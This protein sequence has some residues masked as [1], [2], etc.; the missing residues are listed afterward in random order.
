[1][2][3]SFKLV[4]FMVNI[5][6]GESETID[7]LYKE[8]K[9]DG[10]ATL[11]PNTEEESI[12]KFHKQISTIGGNDKVQIVKVMLFNDN[13]MMIKSEELIKPTEITE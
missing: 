8:V 4:T 9:I 7:H 1:M 11:V 6:G 13:G 2:Y 12:L 10:V 3:K 5:N